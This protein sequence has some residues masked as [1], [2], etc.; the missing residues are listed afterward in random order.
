MME[1]KMYT[2]KYEY[3]LTQIYDIIDNPQANGAVSNW[4]YTLGGLKGHDKA[5]SQ[6]SGRECMLEDSCF[7][8]M[9][10]LK[11]FRFFDFVIKVSVSM[12]SEGIVGVMFRVEDSANYYVFEMKSLDYKRIRRVVKGESTIIIS[13]KDG[14]F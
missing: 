7:A 1:W 14:G 5:I 11:I 3:R 2:E 6:T 4:D 8:T 12:Q 13:K 10:V 9:L